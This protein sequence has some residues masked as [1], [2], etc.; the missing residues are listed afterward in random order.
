MTAE[1]LRKVAY[2]LPLKPF[3]VKLTTG[4]SLQIDRSLRTSVADD[5]VVFGVSQE[6]KNGANTRLRMIALRDI[7]EVEVLST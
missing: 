6:P 2:Q 5:R 4:E 1:E 7:A 3:R